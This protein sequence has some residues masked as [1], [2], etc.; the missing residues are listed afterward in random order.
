MSTTAERIAVMQA[1]EEDGAHLEMRKSGSGEWFSYGPSCQLW[2]W[3]EYD[4]RIKPKV[5]EYQHLK[6][7]L[8]NGKRIRLLH[9]SGAVSVDWNG[10]A[11]GWAFRA[12]ADSY[13][14][15]PD[16]VPLD[17]SDMRAV[18]EVRETGTDFAARVSG[19]GAEAFLI[20]TGTIRYAYALEHM[21]WRGITGDWKA[22]NKGAGE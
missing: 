17:A 10:S 18:Y 8:A 4:Y 2:N 21:E 9:E 5:D 20:N 11:Y 12:P 15:E 16:K 19:Y 3:F 7:A 14:I 22:M 13:E 1:S 6:D